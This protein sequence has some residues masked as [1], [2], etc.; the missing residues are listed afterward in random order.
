MEYIS[1]FKKESIYLSN[2]EDNW[3]NIN[4]DIIKS[5]E[6]NTRTINLHIS[7]SLSGDRKDFTEKT[8]I[9]K[10]NFHIGNTK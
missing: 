6:C 7:E 8:S 1:I 10:E 5:I 4:W 2:K 9:L 3:D